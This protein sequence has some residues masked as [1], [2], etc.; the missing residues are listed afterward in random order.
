MD[1][2]IL[3]PNNLAA[4]LWTLHGRCKSE[5]FGPMIEAS[6][7]DISYLL[8]LSCCCPEA[9]GSGFYIYINPLPR[10]GAP[11][12]RPFICS[13]NETCRYTIIGASREYKELLFVSFLSLHSVPAFRS[14]PGPSFFDSWW[15]RPDLTCLQPLRAAFPPCNQPTTHQCWHCQPAAS[16]ALRIPHVCALLYFTLTLEWHVSAAQAAIAVAQDNN[17][18]IARRSTA[19]RSLT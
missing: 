4:A 12:G 14:L 13:K 2:R 7:C 1:S 3:A 8:L 19:R 10:S 16:V 15:R 11:L 5:I 18:L 17:A 6:V 9:A